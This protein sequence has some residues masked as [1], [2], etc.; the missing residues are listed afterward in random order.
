MSSLVYSTD[1]M[2]KDEAATGFSILA[3]PN[4]VKIAKM[5]YVKGDLSFD[6][7]SN[8]IDENNECL[9]KSLNIMVTSSLIKKNGE[10]FSI[11]KEYVDELLDFIKTPCKCS[12]K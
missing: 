9:I 3:N 11:N 10:M 12:H 1:V 5:L 6:D 2:H 4:R 8:L 7:L